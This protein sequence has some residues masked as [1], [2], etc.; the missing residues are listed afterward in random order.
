M[1]VGPNYLLVS[2]CA[3]PSYD[4]NHPPPM[5]PDCLSH[6][7]DDGPGHDAGYL[8]LGRP[9]RQLPYRP[10]F[11]RP[12]PPVGYPVLRVLASAC[13]PSPDVYLLV[14]DEVVVLKAG[15]A[16]DDLDCFPVSPRGP[17]SASSSIAAK[18]ASKGL[19]RYPEGHIAARQAPFRPA[20]GQQAPCMQST[21]YLAHC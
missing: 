7:R 17:W 20:E 18:A 9:R 14:D 16:T 8:L 3:A 12:G 1:S 13:V 15:K 6:T 2:G 5:W 4:H 10:G 11:F 19:S 21:D